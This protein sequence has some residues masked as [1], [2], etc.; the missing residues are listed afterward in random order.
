MRL[1]LKFVLVCAA[2][3]AAI[4]CAAQ[5]GVVL[6][7]EQ[8]RAEP[9]S[10]A[11]ALAPLP[12]DTRVEVLQ[13]QGAWS[14]VKAAGKQGWVRSLNLRTAA[15]DSGQAAGVLALESGRSGSGNAVATLGIRGQNPGPDAA[16]SVAQGRR[17]GG[18][19]GEGGTL[20]ELQQQ[21]GRQ[22][23]EHDYTAAEAAVRQAIE[24][25][26]KRGA[27]RRLAV[28]YDQL[29]N[30]EMHRG[31]YPEAEA[32]IRKS[33][34]M[35]EAEFGP[36]SRR[37][38]RGMGHLGNALRAN[39]KYGEAD[40][41]L[42]DALERQSSVS[43][44]GDAELTRALT[45]Y[46]I[47]L[48][49]IGQ[50][51][52]AEELYQKAIANGAGTTDAHHLQ[53]L[54]SAHRAYSRLLRDRKVF[55]EAEAEAR[56]SL[57]I[58]EQLHGA[59]H[60]DIARSLI[61]LGESLLAQGRLDAAEAALRRSLPMCEKYIGK[62][63][64][65]TAAALSG[66][67]AVLEQRGKIPE[68]S[69]A[70]RRAVE[71][72][73]QAATQVQQLFRTANYARFLSRQN[74]AEEALVYFKQS[75]DL[76]EA[77]FA[78]TR[79]LDEEARQEFAGRYTPIYYHTV[80]TLLQLHRA[81]PQA[82]YDREALAVVSRTQSRLFTEML[83]QADVS[84]FSAEPRFAA[85]KR[86]RDEL[87][88]Q[89]A[90]LR[91]ARTIAF[92]DADPDEESEQKVDPFIQ[93]RMEKR[94]VEFN[95]RIEAAGRAL[96]NVENQ[97]WQDYPRFM[98]LAQPRAVTVDDLQKKL[99][100]PGETLLSY[101][102][103][104]DAVAIFVISS[105]EFRMRVVPQA[106]FDVQQLVRKARRAEEQASTSIASLTQLDPAVLNRLYQLLIQPVEQWLPQGRPI[107]VAGDS[108][109]LTL[110]LEMLVPR[111]G[112]EERR[113]FEA[114]RAA[115]KLLFNEYA[116]LSYLGEK[117]RFVYLPSLSALASQRQYAKPSAAY[118]RELVS[119]ADPVFARERGGD[120]YSE[121]TRSALQT[122]ARSVTGADRISI[123]R[124]PETADEAREIAR[125]VGGKTDLF[126]RGEAQERTAKTLD[127]KKTRFLHFATH[128]LL[129]GEFLLVKQSEIENELETGGGAQRNLAV[130][131]ATPAQVAPP[132]SQEAAQ[133]DRG[134]QP[135]LVLTLVGDLKGEDGLLTM[136]E[137]IEDLDLNAE[138]VVLSACN[139]AGESDEAYNGEGFAGLTRAFMYA[140]ARS[141]LVSHWAVESVSTQTLMTDTFRNLKQGDA[142]V[143]ALSK[144]RDH[145]RTTPGNGGGQTYSRAHPYFW[146]PF[147][148]VGG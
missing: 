69:D 101:F 27:T 38:L 89:A 26:E 18:G 145:I 127:L 41:V 25:A 131:A 34:P 52:R 93:A 59:E 110:P 1:G 83:R 15:A 3:A 129:G 73:G 63:T 42:R 139:T 144:A 9:F 7:D 51:L 95:Q 66:L 16:K 88:R 71:V 58:D 20:R 114:E 77:G 65:N 135:A 14:L 82:G 105:S 8:L 132:A 64:T 103:L 126:L 137:V 136:R 43:Q 94:R 30:I 36:T 67:G 96:K 109:M 142:I 28:L 112:E 75:L 91:R 90:D 17:G 33:L 76:I 106:R 50:L 62:L 117:Y 22:M 116:T 45:Q 32:L 49:T 99:L 130:S 70:M 35:R 128:G 47:L 113:R 60:G 72:S 81:K 98:E 134:G 123:P 107:L 85:L 102:V 92:R 120:G 79:G 74:R 115:S 138:L 48:R 119:F 21:G 146:A 56:A 140:G 24:I 87:M 53:I 46:A 118:E 10:D 125:T 39:G 57:A 6:R 2:L 23:E 141:L 40:K 84:K 86:E 122:L 108:A 97:L 147:V 4:A 143:T 37:T 80:K 31:H 68:A 104:P 148:H 111:Y 121:T 61:Q 13:Q 11:K 124:L 54:A 100:R 55:A 19:G 12:K 29:G 78:S 44:P 5:P 133:A